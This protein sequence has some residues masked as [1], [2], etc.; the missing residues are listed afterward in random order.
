MK[1]VE[2]AKYETIVNTQIFSERNTFSFY[3]TRFYERGL[4]HKDFH[5]NSIIY[6][7]GPLLLF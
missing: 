7:K 6:L 5:R 1:R 2:K 4:L 3:W